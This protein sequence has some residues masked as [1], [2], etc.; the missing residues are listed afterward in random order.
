VQKQQRHGIVDANIIVEYHRMHFDD[1]PV[2][3][4]VGLA[5]SMSQQAGGCGTCSGLC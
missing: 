1:L 5:S 3:F 2:Y 4:A